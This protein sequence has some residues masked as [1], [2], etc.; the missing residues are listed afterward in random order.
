M[1]VQVG[2]TVADP[3]PTQREYGAHIGDVY[4]A[5]HNDRHYTHDLI[6]QDTFRRL[7]ETREGIQSTESDAVC[8][9]AALAAML[10]L[11]HAEST[12]TSP[13]LLQE[14]L[15]A[16]ARVYTSQFE[17]QYRGLATPFEDRVVAEPY[18]TSDRQF[19]YQGLNREAWVQKICHMQAPLTKE[20]PPARV[21]ER[22]LLKRALDSLTEE[23]AS[24]R[25]AHNLLG[26]TNDLLTETRHQRNIALVAV[27]GASIAAGILGLFA[28]KKAGT[29]S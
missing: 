19:Y 8:L 4:R 7:M 28:W 26:N 27:M 18:Y 15:A 29:S 1:A 21:V 2:I 23:R 11:E 22:V 24:L 13:E 9:R 10:A 17:A 6:P 20:L 5:L 25:R 3:P 12:T 14:C 16:A